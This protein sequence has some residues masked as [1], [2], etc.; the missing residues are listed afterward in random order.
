MRSAAA[1]GADGEADPGAV[2]QDVESSEFGQGE[3]ERRLHIDF[4][5]DIAGEE[6]R[7]IAES[8]R[9]ISAVVV[10]IKDEYAGTGCDKSRGRARTQARCAAGDERDNIVHLHGDSPWVKQAEQD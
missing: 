10:A 2:Y 5:S 1:C 6:T 3:I 9:D 7:F 4:A 8:C